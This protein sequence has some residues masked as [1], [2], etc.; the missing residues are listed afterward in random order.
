MNEYILFVKDFY[1]KKALSLCISFEDLSTRRNN[2]EQTPGE[3]DL[4]VNI[5]RQH[6]KTF[7]NIFSLQ[8]SWATE[9]TVRGCRR[10]QV[11]A[12]RNFASQL[13]SASSSHIGEVVEVLGSKNQLEEWSV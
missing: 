6:K 9:S 13:Y 1:C 11:Y 4:F 12:G 2:I 10:E 3:V 8:A 5:W 7:Y